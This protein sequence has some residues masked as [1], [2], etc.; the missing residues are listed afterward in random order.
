MGPPILGDNGVKFLVL[1]PKV[2][3]SEGKIFLSVEH[4]IRRNNDWPVVGIC[5]IAMFLETIRIYGLLIFPCDSSIE[6]FVD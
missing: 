2:L 3:K 1:V 6:S 4:N 5:E